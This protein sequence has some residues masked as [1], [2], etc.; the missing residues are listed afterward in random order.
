MGPSTLRN[1]GAKSSV[2]SMTRAMMLPENINVP[3][4]TACKA[5]REFWWRV[6]DAPPPGPPP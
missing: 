2:A 5:R 6:V 4:A 3:A 1:P